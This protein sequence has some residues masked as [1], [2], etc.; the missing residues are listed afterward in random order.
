MVIPPF[1]GSIPEADEAA[2]GSSSSRS[3]ASS[4]T[5]CDPR[6]ALEYDDVVVALIDV[7]SWSMTPGRDLEDEVDM[8][9]VGADRKYSRFSHELDTGQPWVPLGGVK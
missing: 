8:L 2:T 4:S 3:P 7:S 1:R 9:I 6:V 5:R